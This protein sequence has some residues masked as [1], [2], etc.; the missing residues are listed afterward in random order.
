MSNELG[1]LDPLQ[2]PEILG[3]LLAGFALGLMFFYSLWLSTNKILHSQHPVA[4][5][6]GGFVL[7]LAVVLPAL[8]WLTDARWE[9]LLISVGGFFIARLL[10]VK[11]SA[12]WQ[13][14]GM[15]SDDAKQVVREP[16]LGEEGNH[17]SES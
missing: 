5:V 16:V 1:G 8:Y 15:A 3:V 10:L 13:P 9:R 4:W 14:T 17:A 2:W 12:K 7:R 11:L 6:L